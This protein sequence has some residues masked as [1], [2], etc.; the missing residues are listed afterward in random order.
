MRGWVR[1][2]S[3]ETLVSC[4]RSRGPAKL[5]CCSSNLQDEKLSAPKVIFQSGVGLYAQEKLKKGLLWMAARLTWEI[6]QVVRLKLVPQLK[7]QVDFNESISW[8]I[9]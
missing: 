3:S 7:S 9:S 1:V 8:V 5:N 4:P 2:N 6:R